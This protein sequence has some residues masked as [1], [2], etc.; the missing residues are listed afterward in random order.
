VKVLTKDEE[1][2]LVKWLGA[3]R[4]SCNSIGGYLFGDESDEG[5]IEIRYAKTMYVIAEIEA[6]LLEISKVIGEDV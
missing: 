6:Q 2:E 3:I 5:P 4:T 1:T